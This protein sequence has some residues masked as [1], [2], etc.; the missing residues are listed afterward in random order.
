MK[1]AGLLLTAI[2]LF[3][4]TVADASVEVTC[5]NELI[6]RKIGQH[7]QESYTFP[8]VG[9]LA[10]IRVYNGDG[11]RWLKRAVAASIKVNGETIFSAK[12]FKKRVATLE[13]QINLLDGENSVDVTLLGI[14]GV[15]FR[16]EILKQVEAQAAGF[17]GTDGGI[18]KVENPT[19]PLYGVEIRFPANSVA[20]GTFCEIRN[21]ESNINPP[22]SDLNVTSVIN[23]E[24]V[25]TL[26]GPVFVEYPLQFDISES[27]SFSALYYNDSINE[28][29]SMSIIG[30]DT[31]NNTVTVLATH[32][33]DS[34]IQRN[35][36]LPHY[37]DQPKTEYKYNRDRF[38][39]QIINTENICKGY[40]QYSLWY[41]FNILSAPETDNFGLSC[42]WDQTTS[43]TVAERAFSALENS[44]GAIFQEM[45][46]QTL[47]L[48]SLAP[49]QQ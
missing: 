40:A 41:Y 13:A 24:L 38:H 1:W 3:V 29:E 48:I 47:A 2:F 9:G 22:D 4:A 34:V 11:D 10:T 21:S 20:D 30:I 8:G 43:N 44:Y 14:P 12:D 16:V 26:T 32:F 27:D 6:Q 39:P 49:E 18:I 28:W 35:R 36:D 5:F 46:D 33:S 23:I 45:N 31:I 25:N 19:S 7:R 17:I 37:I 42:R 15:K